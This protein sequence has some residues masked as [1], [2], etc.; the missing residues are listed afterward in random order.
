MEDIIEQFEHKG[1]TVKLCPDPDA[2][3]PDSWENDNGVLIVTTKNRYFDV[4]PKDWKADHL[5]DIMKAAHLKARKYKHGNEYY[6][7]RLLYAYVHS[8]VALSLS[9]TG[10]FADNWDGG[11]IG[12]V[13]I[14]TGVVGHGKK[15]GVDACATSH[16]K[17]WNDYL[18][19]SVYGY[20]VED[21]DGNHLDS[22]WGF[23]G[24]DY[25]KQEAIQAANG[26]SIQDV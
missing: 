13:L 25:C 7:V 20:V 21:A 5:G 17:T 23:Y 22:C 24:L 14:K 19:G 9:H 10:Q 12:A 16:V 3:S 1:L 6:H 15:H 26:H 2:E 11:L 18:S 8:G 4:T